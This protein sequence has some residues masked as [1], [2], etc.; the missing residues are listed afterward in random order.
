MNGRV[1]IDRHSL[2]MG[3]LWVA[4][5]GG[6]AATYV[7]IAANTPLILMVWQ[8]YDD[9]LFVRLGRALAEGR[10]LGAYD[11]VTLAKGPGYPIFLAINAWMGIPVTVAHAGF[12]C[13]SLAVLAWVV[14]KQSGSYLL[15]AAFFVLPLFHPSILEPARVIRDSIYMSQMVLVVAM[16]AYALF[17]AASRRK[18]LAASAVTGLLLGWF[19]LSR[20]EGVG[21]LPGLAVLVLFAW[22]HGRRTQTAT[23]KEATWVVAGVFLATQLLFGFL[24]LLAYDKFVGVE[25]KERSFQ[26]AISAM[27]SVAMEAPVDYVAVPRATRAR[28]YDVSPAFASLRPYLDPPNGRNAFESVGCDLRPTTCGDIGD[29]FFMWAVRSA[30]REAGHFQS[31]ATASRFFGRIHQDILQACEDGRLQCKPDLVP[32]MSPLTDAQWARIPL[33][34]RHT[35]NALRTPGAFPGY[36]KDAIFGPD[37][38]IDATLS[39]LNWPRHYPADRRTFAEVDLAGWYY[40]GS[41]AWFQATLIDKGGSGSPP[42]VQRGESPDL[43]AAM[44]EAA[45]Q[46]FRIRGR[47]G[48]DCRLRFVADDGTILEIPVNHTDRPEPGTRAFGQGLLTFD[49]SNIQFDARLQDDVRVRAAHAA[50]SALYRVYHALMPALLAAGLL[51]WFAAVALGVR[52]RVG[53][54]ALALACTAWVLVASRAVILV[55]VDVSSF[56]A[57]HVPYQ[58]PMLTMAIVASIASLWALRVGLRRHAGV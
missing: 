26:N 46:R 13:A 7:F 51:A 6:V 2:P 5:M 10:W 23:W 42:E 41:D 25:F 4:L 27:Q 12:Y 53:S 17:F 19:W 22:H 34:V 38:E 9:A 33:S 15:A 11:E 35:W 58:L 48:V 47:C 16:M 30:A 57:L 54:F 52:N 28:L 20:E 37:A 40:A 21:I 55:M 45:R 43:V 31:P 49:R 3:T 39:F 8:G 56:H 18:R 44:P 24:N 36:S 29:G 14:L 1:R 32:M 50:R